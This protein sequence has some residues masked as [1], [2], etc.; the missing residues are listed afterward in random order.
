MYGFVSASMSENFEHMQNLLD[1]TSNNYYYKSAN[2]K[3]RLSRSALLWAAAGEYERIVQGVIGRNDIDANVEDDDGDTPLLV[4]ARTGNAKVVELLLQLGSHV[5]LN[6]TNI[7]MRQGTRSLRNAVEEANSADVSE[8][9]LSH[10]ADLGK[11]Y[12]EPSLLHLAAIKQ[13]IRNIE[14]LIKYGFD[15][16]IKSDIHRGRTPLAALVHSDCC[17]PQIPALDIL[18]K[19]GADLESRN[20]DGRTILLEAITIRKRKEVVIYLLQKGAN[21]N[22]VDG[23]GCNAPLYAIVKNVNTKSNRYFRHSI[24]GYLNRMSAEEDEALDIVNELLRKGAIKDRI[25]PCDGL[26]ALQLARNK[27][28]SKIAQIL[29]RY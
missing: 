19:M 9:L 17:Y 16:N 7:Y 12:H 20:Y 23:N 29:S 14:N 10:G 25:D 4:A 18:L 2:S 26:T 22:V 11:E 8:I 27:N 21:P 28:L 3:K 5:G 6:G 24:D 1:R 15:P 13:N